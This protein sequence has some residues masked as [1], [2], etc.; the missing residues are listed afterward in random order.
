MVLLKVH[1]PL[2]D[3][4]LSN[5]ELDLNP[6]HK[7]WHDSYLDLL[8]NRQKALGKTITLSIHQFSPSPDTKRHFRETSPGSK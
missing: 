6:R 4:G 7:N 1:L 3:L 8:L 2:I 5:R